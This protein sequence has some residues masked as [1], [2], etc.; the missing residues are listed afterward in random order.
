MTEVSVVWDLKPEDLNAAIKTVLNQF[1]NI[2]AILAGGKVTVNGLTIEPLSKN[3]VTIVNPS[4][5]RI[6]LA[7][8]GACYL[9]VAHITLQQVTWYEVMTLT[10]PFRVPNI[11]VRYKTPPVFVDPLAV[12]DDFSKWVQAVA[13]LVPAKNKQ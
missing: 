12:L 3:A 8:S 13:S 7:V 9:E 5:E 10:N 6:T 1:N 11:K 4:N 2:H